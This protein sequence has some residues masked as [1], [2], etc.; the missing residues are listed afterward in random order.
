MAHP[1]KKEKA[2]KKII[3]LMD[4]YDVSTQDVIDYYHRELERRKR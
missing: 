3:S 4:K 2:V 1:R